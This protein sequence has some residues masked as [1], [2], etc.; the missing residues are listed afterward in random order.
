MFPSVSCAGKAWVQ[1]PDALA[2]H[3]LA[4]GGDIILF[5]MLLCYSFEYEI[6]ICIIELCGNVEAHFFHPPLVKKVAVHQNTTGRLNHAN[7][8]AAYF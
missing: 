6:D 4:P 8:L 3:R 5:N 7:A 1:K 2:Q